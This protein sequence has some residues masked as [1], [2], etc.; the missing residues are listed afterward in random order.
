MIDKSQ[1]T[2]FVNK[3]KTT[4]DDSVENL[5]AGVRSRLNQA[6]QGALEAGRQSRWS[7]LI[8]F[9]YA[10]AATAAVLVLLASTVLYFRHPSGPELYSDIADVEILVTGETPDFYMELDFY[11]WLAEEVENA[12]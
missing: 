11:T 3:I 8:S 9:R 4:L 6:R 5:D 1:E 2:K 12:G 10:A 7:G